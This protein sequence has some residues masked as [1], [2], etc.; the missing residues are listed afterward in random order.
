VKKMMVKKL[1]TISISVASLLTIFA[2]PAFA[3]VIVYPHQV[4]V[5]ATQD[6]TVNV[7]NEKDNPVVS[8]KLLLPDGLS[9][10]V[11]YVV[12]GWTI[13]TKS[14]GSDDNATV[15]EIDWSGGSIPG[16]Q[17]EK[18]GFIAQVPGKPT[19]LNWKAY[20]TYSDGTVVSWDIDPATMKNL[21]DAQQDAMADK[22]NKGEYST[23]QVVNDLTGS[24]TMTPP[25]N[26]TTMTD[27]TKHDYLPIGLSIA[28]LALSVVAF[29]RQ[30]MQKK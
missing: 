10:V 25:A 1:T 26:T 16:G 28:A 19:T 3:H 14:S 30:S 22:E 11:P 24:G 5:A 6:F 23:T 18:L 8:V 15:T 7:P 29:G 13:S 17:A 4:G 21:S 2:I 9:S 20:Q 27:N 12:P